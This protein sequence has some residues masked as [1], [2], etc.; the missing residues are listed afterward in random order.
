MSTPPEC[1]DERMLSLNPAS[2]RFWLKGQ[3]F[4]NLRCLMMRMCSER[5]RAS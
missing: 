3:H 2:S 4:D 5:G 1:H